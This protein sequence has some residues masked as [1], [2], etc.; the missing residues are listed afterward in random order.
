MYNV[1]GGQSTGLVHIISDTMC[2]VEGL[3]EYTEYVFSITA[4]TSAGL[5]P[6]AET[7]E[8]TAEDGMYNVCMYIILYE[9]YIRTCLQVYVYAL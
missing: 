4:A 3:N 5:G 8:R 9:P 2:T 1:V 7:T 6:S